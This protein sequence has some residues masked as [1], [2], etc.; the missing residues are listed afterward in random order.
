M[1]KKTPLSSEMRGT[2]AVDRASS[3]VFG[4][5]QDDSPCLSLNLRDRIPAIFNRH[6]PTE[7]RLYRAS[8]NGFSQSG[9]LAVRDGGFGLIQARHLPILASEHHHA[10]APSVSRVR[11][12]VG[13]ELWFRRVHRT[14]AGSE[15]ER[16][17]K[18]YSG[19]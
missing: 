7:S 1:S 19:L 9:P 18:S 10:R 16:S 2:F 13:R 14:R 6:Q 4:F 11:A 17:S 5:A 8:A 12:R 3:Q 15:A